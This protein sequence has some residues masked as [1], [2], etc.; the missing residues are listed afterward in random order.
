[1]LF[2]IAFLFSLYSFSNGAHIFSG[3]TG[4]QG[5][6][7]ENRN[8][9]GLLDCGIQVADGGEVEGKKALIL[10][11]DDSGKEVTV[12][13]GEVIRI[14]LERYGGTGYDWHLE[15]SFEG[16]FKLVKEEDIEEVGG[17]SRAIIGA[18][19]KKQWE[20]RAVSKGKTEI[21]IYLYR[22]WEGRDKAVDSFKIRLIILTQ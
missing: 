18:P 1:M 20:L 4:T 5:I 2:I 17:E 11:K 16:H 14:E 3:S 12:G 15:K 13:V 6:V 8:P 22:N 9:S 10:R 19:V 21:A 7:G